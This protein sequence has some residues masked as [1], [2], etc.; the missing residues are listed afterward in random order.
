MANGLE[1][2]CPFLDRRLVEWAAELDDGLK[3]RGGRL[4]YILRLAYRELLPE[5]VLARPKM[6][7]GVPLG[8][9]M[10]TGLRDYCGDLLLGSSA[11]IRG[12][13]DPVVVQNLF[14]E[15]QSGRQDYGQKIWALLTLEVWL[16]RIAARD[17]SEPVEGT[18]S[19][20]TEIRPT[21]A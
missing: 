1:V 6:G 19:E 9:W 3:V 20:S 13:L 10:R 8:H 18:V 21:T 7:F 16:R 12:L 14:S 11:K 2:R 5:E 4:K 15:H 17:R